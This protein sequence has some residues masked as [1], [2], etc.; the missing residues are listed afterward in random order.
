MFAMNF[1]FNNPTEKKNDYNFLPGQTEVVKY[2]EYFLCNEKY[3]G[4]YGLS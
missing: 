3:K 1:S 2:S 4:I